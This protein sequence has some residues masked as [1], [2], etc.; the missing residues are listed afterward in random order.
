MAGALRGALLGGLLLLACAACGEAIDPPVVAT[1]NFP[2]FRNDVYPVLLRDC[3]TVECH[4]D[5]KRFFRVWGPGRVRLPL[6]NMTL[7]EALDQPT[8][9]EVS[10]TYSLALS[11]IDERDLARSPLLRKP[12]AV[13]AGGSGHMGVDNYGRDVYR[14]TSDEGYQAIARWV[15]SMPTT[16]PMAAQPAP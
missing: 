2:S 8:G 13:S 16:P 5:A 10:T 15:F 4:G 14:T 11:M 1:R 9:T 6:E 12:L 3:A 7:P